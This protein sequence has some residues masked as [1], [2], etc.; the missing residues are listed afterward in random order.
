MIANSGR[1]TAFGLCII[2]SAILPAKIIFA[3]VVVPH[4]GQ[5]RWRI[6]LEGHTI[7]SCVPDIIDTMN[8]TTPVTMNNNRYR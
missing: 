4:P 5:G 7:I 8:Q 1:S 6:N 2:P 3:A